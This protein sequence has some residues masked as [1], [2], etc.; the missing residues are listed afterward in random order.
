[1]KKLTQLMMTGFLVLMAAGSLSAQCAAGFTFT[2]NG[3]TVQFTNTSSVGGTPFYYWNFGDNTAGY[4]TNPSHT[5][6][7][8]GSYV[9]CLTVYDSTFM[10]TCS[11]TFC[12]SV[13][14]TNSPCNGFVVNMSTTNE[15]VCG[16]CDGTATANVSG[17]TA[18]YAYQWGQLSATTPSVSSLCSGGEQVTVTDANGCSSTAY[19]NVSCTPNNN[20]SA[21]FTFTVNNGVVQFTNTSTGGNFPGYVWNFGDNGSAFTTSPSHSYNSNGWYAVC[22]TMY[23]SLGNCSSTYCDSLQI[24]NTLCNNLAATMTTVNE[25][26]CNACDGSASV[27]VTGGTAPYSYQWVNNSATTATV[28]PLCYGYQA[29]TITDANGCSTSAMGLVNCPNVFGCQAYFYTSTNGNTVS[30]VNQSSGGNPSST[31][32]TWNFGDNSYATGQNPA[33]HTYANNGTYYVCLTMSDSLCSSTYCDTVVIGNVTPNC[34]V[35]FGM[36]QDS[37]N[38]LLWY[39][40]PFVGGTAPFTYLWDFGDNSTSTQASPTHSYNAPGQYTVCLMITDATGCT[41][42]YCD[43]TSVQRIMQNAQSNQMQFLNVGPVVISGVKENTLPGVNLAP[44]PADQLVNISFDRDVKANVRM[45]NMLGSVVYEN[46]NEGQHL[47]IDVSKLP[48]GY[49]NITVDTETGRINKK[50]VIVRQ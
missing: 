38:P 8:N 4:T 21:G 29:V 10:S 39:A 22:L 24:T 50:V 14:I 36:Y 43:S 44:N 11:S 26:S 31:V 34:S 35:Y 15:S 25:S 20:C 12:D 1:M 28:S 37:L 23:D 41:S 27:N 32:Y 5:Y 49:Y 6:S 45:T 9:I 13:L 18:P 33:P 46:H 16:A 7:N 48:A 40:Y 42:A 3:G 17:G 19:G 30:F 47:L 2:V